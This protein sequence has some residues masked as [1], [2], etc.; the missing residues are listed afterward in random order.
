VAE[1]V[2]PLVSSGAI[3]PAPQTVFRLDQAAEAHRRLESGDNLGKI[4]LTVA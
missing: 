2:W 3:T 1:A 4:I